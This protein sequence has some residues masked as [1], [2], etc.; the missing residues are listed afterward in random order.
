M[1]RN[2]TFN[3]KSIKVISCMYH[4]K[5]KLIKSTCNFN[6]NCLRIERSLNRFKN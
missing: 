5:I 1:N 3:N 2:K 6:N 4:Y